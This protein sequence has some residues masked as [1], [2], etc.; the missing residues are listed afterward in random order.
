M[1]VSSF[2]TEGAKV[3]AGS[4]VKAMSTETVLPQWYTDAA[5]QTLSNQLAVA[6]Q[7]YAM[8]PG[9]R[10]AEF[11]PAQQQGFGMTQQAAGAYRPGLDA[12]TAATQGAMAGP[13][14]LATAQPYLGAAGQSSVANIGQYMNPYNDAVTGR[15]AELGSRNLTENILPGIEGRYIAAGQLGFGGRGGAAG[16][17]SG[18]MTDTAR[19]VR[20]VS[21]NILAEQNKALQSGYSEAAGLA[22]G[23]LNRFGAL[24]STAGNLGGQDANRQLAG[25]EQLGGLARAQ[26]ELG[27]KGA[28][29]VTGVG[30]QQQSQAQKNID[31]AVADFM[32]AQGHPQEMIDATLRTMQGI[33]GAV[34]K[35]VNEVGITPTGSMPPST[36]ETIV[37]GLTAGAG[38]LK[39]LKVI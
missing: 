28:E 22:A 10:V 31:V 8:F 14:G 5:M 35:G 29:A 34:P 36:G 12:A 23:D 18:M 6:S 1:S 2:L 16:T 26:Q 27:L 17:P 20:D 39:E 13:G 32:R 9:P 21:G 3:P 15:I 4:A 38:L 24:A 30:A 19:A 11:S 33:S 7:P 25:A 37:G